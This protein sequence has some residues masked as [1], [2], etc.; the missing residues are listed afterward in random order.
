M[1]DEALEQLR[2][3]SYQQVLTN[4]RRSAL[5]ELV[6]LSIVLLISGLLFFTHWRMA[7]RTTPD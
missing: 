4:H 6:R 7:R 1:S 2:R 3:K 5:Q